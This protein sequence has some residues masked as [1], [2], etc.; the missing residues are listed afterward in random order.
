MKTQAAVLWETGGTWSV[1]DVELD[2]PKDK[3]VRVKLTSSGLCHSD[4][5][6]VTGD[7]PAP[8][9]IVGGHE[10]AGIVEAIGSAVTGI[11]EGDH[12]VLGFI[13]S[14]GKCEA[15]S[16]GYQ[17]LCEMGAYILSGEELAGGQRVHT[18][19]ADIGTMC[20]LGTFAPYVIVHEDSVIKIDDNIPLDKA[21]LVGCGVTTGVGSAIYAG[22]VRAGDTVVVNGCGGIGSNAIQGAKIAGATQI[23]AVDPVQFKLDQ[24]KIFGATHFAFSI[25]EV[26]AMIG[27]LTRGRKANVAIITTGIGTGDLVAPTMGLVGKNGTVVV[28]AI[29]PWTQNDVSLSLLDMTLYQKQLKGSLFGSA[30][31]RADIPKLLSWYMSGA[32]KLDELVTTTYKLADIEQGYADMRSGK[33]IRGMILFD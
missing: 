22:R 33:N 18:K 5:H 20:C 29:A 12:V 23:I 17:N 25:E 2:D 10:G 26:Q 14:C 1:E 7:L 32:L 21:S 31:P 6:L 19:G 3:E 9:P 27:D 30:N 16:Q 28:T 24:A 13:P 15:C 11:Q 8:L 4:E